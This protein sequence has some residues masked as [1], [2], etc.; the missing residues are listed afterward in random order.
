MCFPDNSCCEVNGKPS[1]ALWRLV[2]HTDVEADSNFQMQYLDPCPNR[3]G[4]IDRLR[5]ETEDRE[6]A[7]TRSLDVLALKAKDRL[8]TKLIEGIQEMAPGV[9]AGTVS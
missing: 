5:W 8:F 1:E 9:G 4:A 3:H 7:V 6:G 2:N